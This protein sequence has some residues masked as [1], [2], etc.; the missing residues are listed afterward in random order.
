MSTLLKPKPCPFC[1]NDEEVEVW[2]DAECSSLL[3]VVCGC[4]GM[5][6]PLCKSERAAIRNWN[7]CIK[8][9]ESK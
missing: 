9:K 1:E 4:C 5:S 3:Q 2:P 7:A 8:Q 6:G